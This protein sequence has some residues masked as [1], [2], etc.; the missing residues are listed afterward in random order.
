LGA[1]SLIVLRDLPGNLRN[2]D[3][4]YVLC[5]D[6]GSAQRIIDLSES[7]EWEADESTVYD[8]TDEAG[9][10]MER[11]RPGVVVEFWWD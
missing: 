10:A 9:A 4:L 1:V 5:E 2:A 7:R 8:R 3:S 11:S 6:A